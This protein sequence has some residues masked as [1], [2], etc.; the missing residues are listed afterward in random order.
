MGSAMIGGW[1]SFDFSLNKKARKVFKEAL[2]GFTGVGYTPLAYATQVV[3]G[4]NYCYLCK[5]EVVYPDRPEFAVKLYI[6]APLKGDPHLTHIE[7][8]EP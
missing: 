2:K 5:G 3:A 4:T 7:K 6:F 8:I 1:T